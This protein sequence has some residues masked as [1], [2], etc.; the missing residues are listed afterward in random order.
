MVVTIGR[1]PRRELDRRD[2]RALDH[3]LVGDSGPD[4]ESAE[5][6]AELGLVVANAFV[7]LGDAP[8]GSV[9]RVELSVCIVGFVG[10]A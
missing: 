5:R 6:R 2:E 4:G 7:H 9:Y 10:K 3:V 1:Q 8:Q